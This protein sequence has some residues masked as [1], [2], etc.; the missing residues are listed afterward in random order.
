MKTS[1]ILSRNSLRFIT[2]AVLSSVSFTSV[3]A[4]A[5]PDSKTTNADK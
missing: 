1:K 2:L 4:I 5:Q 3:T